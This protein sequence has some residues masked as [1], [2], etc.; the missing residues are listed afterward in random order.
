VIRLRLLAVAIVVVQSASVMAVQATQRPAF[1]G[2]W[3]I[4]PPN[5]AAGQEQ[6]VKQDDKTLTVTNAG[7]TTSY[8]LN[9]VER[10][11]ARSTRVGEVVMISKAAWEGRT[12]VI[13][14]ATLYPNDMKTTEKEIWSIDKQGQLVIDFVETTKGE[15]PRTM[16]I[17]HKKKS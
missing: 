7:R 10:R 6:I 3:I 14:T 12:I 13:T 5:K 9:G 17:T 15:P 11:E 4:Q 2:T 1:S 8:Q 16:T